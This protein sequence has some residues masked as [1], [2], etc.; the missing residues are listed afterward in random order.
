MSIKSRRDGRIAMFGTWIAP[1]S[2]EVYRMLGAGMKLEEISR[3]MNIP[4]GSMSGYLARAIKFGVLK[5]KKR[6]L[7]L[8]AV[9]QHDKK[10]YE[11]IGKRMIEK[12]GFNYQNAYYACSIEGS[13]LGFDWRFEERVDAKD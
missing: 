9:S 5:P 3:Q 11:F 4:K 6:K 13:Y 10:K 12:E 8:V 7:K 1:H 2:A